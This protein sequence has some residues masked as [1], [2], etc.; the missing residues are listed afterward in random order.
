MTAVRASD[1][2]PTAL[3]LPGYRI[4]SAPTEASIDNVVVFID[5]VYTGSRFTGDPHPLEYDDGRQILEVF[6]IKR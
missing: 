4:R 3:R 6:H 5:A 2:V 1:E